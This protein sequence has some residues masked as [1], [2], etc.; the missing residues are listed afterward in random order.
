VVLSGL[1]RGR[2]N[3]YSTVLWDDDQTAQVKISRFEST[4]FSDVSEL[5]KDLD[6]EERLRLLYVAATRARDHLVL[7][8]HTPERGDNDAKL[9][10]STAASTG[11]VHGVLDPWATIGPSVAPP[12]GADEPVPLSLP[13]P[14]SV[15]PADQAG[16]RAAW[17]ADRERLLASSRRLV[18][19]AATSLQTAD[20]EKPEPDDEPDRHRL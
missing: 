10:A 20:D 5:S 2:D 7:S 4:G 18:S 19:R 1:N 14:P 6:K 16:A 11:A 8:L 9:L 17:L 13:L 15:E 3:R 12:P